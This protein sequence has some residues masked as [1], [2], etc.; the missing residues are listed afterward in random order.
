MQEALLEWFG[1]SA[2]DLPWRRTR[3]PYAILVS[4]VMLQQTQV[5]RVLERY[6]PWLERWPTP[7]ALAAAPAADV[8]RAWSGLGYNR[9]A[10]NLQNAARRV[11]ELGEFPSDIDGLE[12]LPGIGPYTARAIACFAFGAQVTALDTNVRRVLERSL[13]TTD[14]A[15]PAGRAWDWNQALFDLGA[16][17]CLARVPRCERCP[18]ARAVP[19]ARPDVRAAA[20]PEPV[21]GLAA[22][23]PRSARARARRRAARRRRL[24]SRR[25]RL[26]AGRRP[27]RA[28][29]RRPARTPRGATGTVKVPSPRLCAEPRLRWRTMV[30]EC[31]DVEGA[32]S[33]GKIGVEVLQRS[34]RQDP[35]AP[36]IALTFLRTLDVQ[37]GCPVGS[38]DGDGGRRRRLSGSPCRS[39]HQRLRS[40]GIELPWRHPQPSC[41]P[42]RPRDHKECDYLAR[43][44]EIT[45]DVVLRK[46]TGQHRSRFPDMLDGLDEILRRRSVRP[47]PIRPC[48][49]ETSHA[50][51]RDAMETNESRGAGSMYSRSVEWPARRRARQNRRSGSSRRLDDVAHGDASTQCGLGR[52]RDDRASERICPRA[53]RPTLPCQNPRQVASRRK[54][55]ARSRRS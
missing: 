43:Q 40:E 11:V 54:R 32:R 2:R 41:T 42:S 9:R 48:E 20:P 22:P 16:Q 51:A 27:G 37:S 15:P 6:G 14:V 24:R 13:G 12:R 29:R 28:P 55:S 10:L 38:R 8:L 18:L 31:S 35:C 19:L 30:L 1:E 52:K 23:A 50:G 4:E 45:L 34:R 53:T 47:R 7:A 25:G 39:L 3:D 17:V 5:A 44:G 26:P 46:A 36:D 49:V 21:R 33:A